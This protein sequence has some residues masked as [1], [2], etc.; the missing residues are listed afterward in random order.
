MN[1]PVNI[2]VNNYQIHILVCAAPAQWLLVV[3]VYFIKPKLF[4]CHSTAPVLCGVKRNPVV[5]VLNTSSWLFYTHQRKHNRCVNAKVFVNFCSTLRCVFTNL[6][7]LEQWGFGLNI[8]DRCYGFTADKANLFAITVILADIDLIDLPLFRKPAIKSVLHH[9][10]HCPVYLFTIRCNHGCIAVVVV[11]SEYHEIVQS[12]FS[13]FVISV[14]NMGNLLD[15]LNK[16]GF[17]F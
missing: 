11:N 5:H 9:C 4:S 16:S 2:P 1:Q 6:F 14:L 12:N 10:R 8:S 3:T 15:L 17:F 7:L 13:G